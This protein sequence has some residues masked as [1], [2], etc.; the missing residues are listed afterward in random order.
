M[1]GLHRINEA[2][3]RVTGASATAWVVSYA[4]VYAVLWVLTGGFG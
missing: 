4:A 1:K 2:T 3:R